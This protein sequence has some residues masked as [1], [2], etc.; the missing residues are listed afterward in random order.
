MDAISQ[1][2]FSNAWISLKISLN[3]V[4][5]VRINNIPAL[6]QIMAC[7]RPGDNLMH[8]NSINLRKCEFA[9]KQLL[10]WV[11]M[12][13]YFQKKITWSRNCIGER[14]CG[15]KKCAVSQPNVQTNILLQNLRIFGWLWM[16]ISVAIVLLLVRAQCFVSAGNFTRCPRENTWLNI[17]I[18]WMIWCG[19]V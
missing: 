1:T 8:G 17:D 4:P 11:M 18:R 14:I 7:R 9:P 15:E 19:S 6:V 16:G 3:F 5:T 12:K 13:W 10:A 2:T